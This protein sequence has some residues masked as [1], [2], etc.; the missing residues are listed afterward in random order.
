[1]N[2]MSFL[3]K[4][5]QKL[6]FEKKLLKDHLTLPSGNSTH[7]CESYMGICKLNSSMTHRRID[8]K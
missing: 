6:T 8:I 1:M 5:I 4:L 3:P 7:G 2:D